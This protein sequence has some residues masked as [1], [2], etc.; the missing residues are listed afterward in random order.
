MFGC[1]FYLKDA[2]MLLCAKYQSDTVKLLGRPSKHIV[3][4]YHA[5]F[6]LKEKLYSYQQNALLLGSAEMVSED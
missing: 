2:H 6:C 1:K 4:F 3:S 5:A